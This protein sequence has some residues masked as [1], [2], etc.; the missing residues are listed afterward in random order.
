MNKAIFLF[1]FVVFAKLVHA[2]KVD[3]IYF[4]L[5]T[6]SLKKGFFNYINIDGKM[7]DGTWVPLSTS[8]VIL[9]TEQDSSL[10]FERNDLFIDSSY[11]K[12]TVTVKAVLKENPKI[13][14]EV[15][16]YIRKRGFDEPLKS[17]QELLDDLQNQRQK[18]KK[19]NLT[20]F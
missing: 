6:D 4:H 12:E 5:Y 11:T 17:N 16:I 14:K 9:T 15:T 3:S 1:L 10:K 13:W 20:S 18:S 8:E 19:K 7:S 2:Q